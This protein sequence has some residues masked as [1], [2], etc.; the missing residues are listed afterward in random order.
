MDGVPV[1]ALGGNY[2]SSSPESNFSLTLLNLSYRRY[3]KFCGNCGMLSRGDNMRRTH[4]P[5][6]QPDLKRHQNGYL[7]VGQ[8]PKTDLV[9]FNMTLRMLGAVEDM[10]SPGLPSNSGTKG[11]ISNCK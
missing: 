5:F 1:I 10:P 11:E 6:C 3:Y 2:P 7:M 9:D 4:F 8:Q